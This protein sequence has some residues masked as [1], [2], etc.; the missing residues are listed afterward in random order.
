MGEVIKMLATGKIDGQEV[1]IELN[2][3]PVDRKKQQVHLQLRGM[4]LEM[5]K[6]RYIQCALSILLAKNNLK[7]VKSL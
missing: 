1:E 5:D 3:S 4:R 6:D 7:R 2:H